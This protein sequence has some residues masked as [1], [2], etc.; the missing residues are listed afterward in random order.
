MFVCATVEDWRNIHQPKKKMP[1]LYNT[2]L[3][4]SSNALLGKNVVQFLTDF[5]KVLYNYLI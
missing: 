4:L 2:H 3:S 1:S 5:G